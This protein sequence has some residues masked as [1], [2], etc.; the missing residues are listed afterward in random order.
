MPRCLT[1]RAYVRAVSLAAA[2]GIIECTSPFW[3]SNRAGGGG[4]VGVDL[5]DLFLPSYVLAEDR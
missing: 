4:G 5:G 2:R 1:G 3:P